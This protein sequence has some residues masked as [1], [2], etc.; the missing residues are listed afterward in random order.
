MCGN[1]KRL[2]VIS[3]VRFREAKGPILEPWRKRCKRYR[4]LVYIPSRRVSAPAV[5]TAKCGHAMREHVNVDVHCVILGGLLACGIAIK[6]VLVMCRV[7]GVHGPRRVSA[8]RGAVLSL[9]LIDELPDIKIPGCYITSCYITIGSVF[10][11][12]SNQL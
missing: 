10:V 4:A 8:I 3:A 9:D 11:A 7:N 6:E 12:G 5:M 2:D 1:A